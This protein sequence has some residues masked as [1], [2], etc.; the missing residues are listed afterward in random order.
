M[1]QLRKFSDVLQ[2]WLEGSKKREKTLDMIKEAK[3]LS[4]QS[5][6]LKEEG[7]F[8]L[9]ETEKILQSF[10]STGNRDCERKPGSKHIPSKERVSLT[11]VNVD[12][13]LQ[14]LYRIKMIS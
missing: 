12:F 9:E 10:P 14:T 6:A 11:E 2:A 5:K 4:Q 1:L 7:Q 8:L 3:E 13:R